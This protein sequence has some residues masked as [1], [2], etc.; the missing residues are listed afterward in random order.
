MGY[1]NDI[2]KQETIR[3]GIRYTRDNYNASSTSKT[4]RYI[5]AMNQYKY[6]SDITF[7]F[8]SLEELDKDG[9]NKVRKMLALESLSNITVVNHPVCKEDNIVG[10]T[11][12]EKVDNNPPSSLKDLLNKMKGDK[13]NGNI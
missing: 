10:S 1:I 3:S 5:E 13:Q 6:S 8:D 7:Y 11:E 4:L 2:R 12:Q 9:Y